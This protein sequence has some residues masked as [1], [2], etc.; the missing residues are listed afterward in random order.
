V[1]LRA[2]GR[3]EQTMPKAHHITKQVHEKFKIFTGELAA[4]KTIGK[5]AGEVSDFAKRS[6]VAAKS[7]GVA[8][9]E[10]SNRLM[11]TLGYRSDEEPY[12]IKLHCIPLGKIGPKD[13][14]FGT[15]EKAMAKATSHHKNII[16]HELY[17][18]G[19]QDLMMVL[20]THEFA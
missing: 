20:M 1:L 7:I 9:L 18:T 11:L 15:L 17:L 13:H 2:E 10:P 14:N 5:M 4:D 3:N 12:A 8:H 19:E 16:C 6:K